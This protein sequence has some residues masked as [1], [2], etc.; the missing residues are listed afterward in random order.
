MNDRERDT[1]DGW[2]EG[3]QVFSAASDA[4]RVRW[5][6]DLAAAALAAAL[7][8]VLVLVA[9]E[10]STLDSNTLEFVT[11]LPGWLL[12]FAQAGYLVGVGYAFALLLGVGIFARDRL[13]L[14]RDM[15][16]AAA[17]AVVVAVL[18]TRFVDERWPE[19]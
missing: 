18:L 6:T 17:L 19:F 14:L 13:E 16:L 9:G 3:I 7:V 11:G 8:L 2:S 4:P 15:L 12:W 5:T 1:A 10:G